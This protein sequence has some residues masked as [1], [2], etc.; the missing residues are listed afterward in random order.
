MFLTKFTLKPLRFFGTIGGGFSL[1]GIAICLYLG[2]MKFGY[3]EGIA[4]RPLLLLGVLLIVLGVQILG[5]GLVGEI[6]I[7]SQARNLKEY[8][9]EQVY[10]SPERRKREEGGS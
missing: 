1:M 7:F 4:G 2:V 6:I 5:F 10:E 8:R 3:G 9:I